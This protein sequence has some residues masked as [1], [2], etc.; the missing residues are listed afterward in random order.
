LSVAGPSRVSTST[1]APRAAAVMGSSNRQTRSCPRRS[2]TG[3]GR[4]ARVRYRSP[5][6]PPPRPSSPPPSM[7]RSIPSETPAGTSTETVC[8]VG[9]RPP[10]LH[11]RQGDAISSP[12]PSH[13][14]HRRDV[15][16]VPNTLRRTSETSP[17]PPQ[18]VHR[19][20]WVPGSAPVPPHRPHISCVSTRTS[21]VA[22]NAASSKSSSRTRWRSRPRPVRVLRRWSGRPPPNGDDPKNA[23]K[24]SVRSPNPNMSGLRPS[25]P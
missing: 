3:C 2:N 20:G 6:G 21:L 17:D 24:M 10:P 8:W 4:T 12:V 13:V 7:R 5:D 15:I 11:S 22:P 9:I 18:V 1:S 25:P 23:S 14:P 19:D 16:T